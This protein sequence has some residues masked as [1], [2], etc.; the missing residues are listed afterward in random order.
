MNA[1]VDHVLTKEPVCVELTHVSGMLVAALLQVPQAQDAL[2]RVFNTATE[3]LVRQPG[4]A[5]TKST[6]VEVPEASEHNLEGQHFT[7]HCIWRNKC[8]SGA[9]YLCRGHYNIQ[10]RVEA[11]HDCH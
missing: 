2:I 6:T 1:R 11:V 7:L 3:P 9:G 10:N 8:Q 5:V 4:Q